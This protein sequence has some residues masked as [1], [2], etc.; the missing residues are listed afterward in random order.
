M[1]KKKTIYAILHNQIYQEQKDFLR[2]LAYKNNLSEAEVVRQILQLGIEAYKQ[3][4]L[5]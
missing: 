1:L 4:A 3:K 5:G 2:E